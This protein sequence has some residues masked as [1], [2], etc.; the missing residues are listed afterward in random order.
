MVEVEQPQIR[1]NQRVDVQPI[2]QDPLFVTP[3]GGRHLG[4]E[5]FVV[6]ALVFHPGKGLANR[7][8]EEVWLVGVATVQ[9]DGD[10]KQRRGVA[11]AEVSGVVSE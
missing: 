11:G 1:V 4:D 8:F 10:E 6:R 5:H 3:V 7:L 2:A 9:G